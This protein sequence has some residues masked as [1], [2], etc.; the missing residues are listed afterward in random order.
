M[1]NERGQ[2]VKGCHPSPA[3]EFRRGQHWRPR[4][5]YW[6]A[7][8]LRWQ[9]VLLGRTAAEIAADWGIHEN[10]IA[11]WLN[12]HRIPTRDVAETRAIK[13]WAQTGPDN[14]M[15]GRTGAQSPAWRG[16]ITAERQAVYQS[17]AWKR[18]VRK[19]W[20]RD[21]AQCKHCGRTMAEYGRA[22]DCHHIV[23]FPHAPLRTEPANL[24][25]LCGHCH[26]FVHSRANT[27]GLFL[28]AEPV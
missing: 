20:T 7:G 5:P 6:S 10:A 23:P 12:K 22:L 1:R 3:T 14:P 15:Y 13:Y 28:K 26:K 25:L 19:V 17:R 8:W 16:G 2:F 9:Y 21:G 24:V 18:A 27:D 4:K 11:Y